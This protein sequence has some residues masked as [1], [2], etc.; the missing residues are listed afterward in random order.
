VAEPVLVGAHAD[1]NAGVQIGGFVP[2]WESR[3]LDQVTEGRA[4]APQSNA[5]FQLD[6]PG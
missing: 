4:E 2:D 1:A 5:G 3:L 6:Q